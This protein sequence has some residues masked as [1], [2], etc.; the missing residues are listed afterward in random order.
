M[1]EVQ[2][3]QRKFFQNYVDT[4]MNGTTAS[5]YRLGIA[6]QKGRIAVGMD[7]DLVLLN[8]ALQVQSVI[9]GGEVVE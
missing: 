4:S 3:M 9:V 6:D 8:E 1:S 2:K 7:A 5:Y